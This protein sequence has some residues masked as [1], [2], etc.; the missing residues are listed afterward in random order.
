MSTISKIRPREILDSRG[1]PT[2]EV[3]LELENGVRSVASVPSGASVGSYEV[4]ELR[5]GDEKRYGGKGVLKAIEAINKNISPALIG[6]DA[7]D[8][9][10]LDKTLADLDGTEHK[11]KLGA[12]AILALSLAICKASALDKK[13]PLYQYISEFSGYKAMFMPR[14]MFNFIEGA[15]HADNNLEIQEFM[16][17]PLGKTF[18]E[19]YQIASE[20]FHVLKKTLKDRKLGIAVGHEGGF[21]PDLEN[22][23]QALQLLTELSNVKIGL[24]M[25]GV[26]PKGMSVDDILVKYPII[27]L[28]DPTGEDD[29]QN[30]VEL[31]RKYTKNILIVGDDLLATNRKRLEEAIAKQAVNA[32]IVKPN[33]IGTVT[34][35]IEFTKLAKSNNLKIVVS[36]RSGET[37]DTFISDFAVGVAAEYVKFGA[38]S[39]GERVCKY[40]RLLRIEERLFANEKS[41]SDNS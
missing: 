10:G 6:Q 11:S 3:E 22:D 4:V 29:W 40:N 31:T 41:I 26:V 25:A 20:Q 15:K 30:W 28:E 38:P 19:N 21:A 32:V 17:I 12:N 7:S 1:D 5:D 9:A 14:P 18:K 34:E 8:Q 27:S 16:V 33:Q 35:A 39:R 24:D 2:V 36:H 37:E 23:E 13:V